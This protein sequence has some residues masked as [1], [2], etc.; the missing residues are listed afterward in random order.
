[1]SLTGL[2]LIEIIG[3]H[4]VV[5]HANDLVESTKVMKRRPASR[6]IISE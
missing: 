6:V 2:Q 4:G 1:M 3:N 5:G